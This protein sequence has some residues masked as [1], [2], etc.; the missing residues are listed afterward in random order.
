MSQVLPSRMECEQENIWDRRRWSPFLLLRGDEN[1]GG[2]QTVKEKIGE[3]EDE[4]RR[5]EE[6][7]GVVPL[8][9]EEIPHSY[10]CKFG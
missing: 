10:E 1:R 3:R 8:S 9:I 2:L 7:P 5:W 6:I 4:S